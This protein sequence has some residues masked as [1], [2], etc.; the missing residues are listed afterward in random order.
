MTDQYLHIAV[1]VVSDDEGRILISERRQDCVYAG[2]WEFPGGKL[3]VGESV[4][5]AL[6]RELEEE[7]GLSIESARPLISLHHVYP[8][9]KVFLDTWKVTAWSG[10][11]ESREGQRFAWV[12]PQALA[13]YPMLEA[14]NPIVRAAQLPAEYLITP[15]CGEDEQVFMTALEASLAAGVHLVRLRQPSLAL[16]AYAALAV[17]CQSVCQS[18]G[19]TLLLDDPGLASR[20]KTGLH[21]NSLDLQSFQNPANLRDAYLAASCHD[22]SDLQR[23]ADIGCDF[24][25]LGPVEMTATHA[26]AQPIGWDTFAQMA[27]SA[28]LPV[29]ALGGMKRADI[30]KSWQSGGQGVA[31]IRGLWSTSET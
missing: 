23:A 11:P 4:E 20:L 8:D 31:A 9:R 16:D 27:K 13:D 24:A 22:L 3:E 17:Q 25:V 28:L 10:Q 26:E 30:E 21:L 19:A 15:D 29:Y 5:V 7:L 14:N 1:G 18:F 12:S 6:V 2:Q